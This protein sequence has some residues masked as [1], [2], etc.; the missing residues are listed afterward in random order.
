V[1]NG[2]GIR[3][4]AGDVL[5]R[6]GIVPG[7]IYRLDTFDVLPFDNFVTVVLN[8][9]PQDIEAIFER[10]AATL[11]DAGGQFLQVAGLRIAYDV[12][13]PVGSRVVSVSLDDGTAII[14]DGAFAPGAPAITVV[15]NNFTASGGDD[16]QTFAANPDKLQLPGS[17]EE[18][19]RLYLEELG[20]VSAG[21]PRY[22]PGGEGRITFVTQQP[23]PEPT[24]TG[25]PPAPT[26]TVP[27]PT[28]TV[29]PA[30]PAIPAPRPPDTGSGTAGGSPNPAIWLAALALLGGGATALA[31]GRRHR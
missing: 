28:P 17:Y 23:E 26:A 20:T 29:T 16:Y 9:T 10:S 5:P 3:Q 24:P 13:R 12:S 2:G 25:E 7:D 14:A 11:P 8:V 27:A 30:T 21:D 18:A 15:T 19:W 6:D 4:N 31:F 1:Q 22:Q